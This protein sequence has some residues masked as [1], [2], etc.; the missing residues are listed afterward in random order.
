MSKAKIKKD[1]KFDN[2]KDFFQK[3]YF[4]RALELKG[5]DG[6]YS[7]TKINE[8]SDFLQDFQTNP[9]NMQELIANRGLQAG[10]P[11]LSLGSIAYSCNSLIPLPTLRQQ[12]YNCLK[13]AVTFCMTL[14]NY[15]QYEYTY[16]ELSTASS[17]KIRCT[18]QYE[19]A[20]V[21]F[22]TKVEEILKSVEQY[23]PRVQN[24]GNIRQL[25]KM[26]EQLGF[27]EANFKTNYDHFSRPS[28]SCPNFIPKSNEGTVWDFSY[29]T[30]IMDKAKFITICND[31]AICNEGVPLDKALEL[32]AGLFAD[33]EEQIL[34]NQNKHLLNKNNTSLSLHKG[35]KNLQ[36]LSIAIDQSRITT[37]PQLHLQKLHS[38]F[39]Q[40]TTTILCYLAKLQ[41][42]S[43]KPAYGVKLHEFFPEKSKEVKSWAQASK[44]TEEAYSAYTGYLKKKWEA[45]SSLAK[46]VDDYKALDNA[47]L[48]VKLTND[49]E[50][51]LGLHEITRKMFGEEMPRVGRWCLEILSTPERVK[52]K[53]KLVPPPEAHEEPEVLPIQDRAGAPELLGNDEAAHDLPAD[54]QL[55]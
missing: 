44:I 9:A 53:V 18:P 10:D 11:I 7:R 1:L 13:N 51:D 46:Q 47:A 24:Q 50:T 30:H 20:F 4:S 12:Q 29:K 17:S 25:Y 3:V 28:V 22:C 38:K 2:F 40:I 21:D 54:P 6:Q 34:R 19:G 41:A 49:I 43:E 8:I 48:F 15:L 42:V 33:H 31:L 55:L 16:L 32:A 23:C 52:I 5:P 27:N 36:T 37:E 35:L 26:V 39:A 45:I 14:I